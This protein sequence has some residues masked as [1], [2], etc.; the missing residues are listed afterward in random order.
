M[1]FRILLALLFPLCVW[2]A[3]PPIRVMS[4]NIRLALDSDG[5]NSWKNRKTDVLSLFNYYQP[6][7]FGVQEALPE[8]INE[9]KNGVPKYQYVG[10]GRDDGRQ[11]G[12]FSAIFYD[13]RKYKTLKSGTF[14]LSETPEKPSKG[15][16]AAY[17][18]VCTYSLFKSKANGKKFW[19]FNLHF[20]HVGTI[21]REK[22]AELV[23]AKIK[24]F[25]KANLPVV[26]MGDFN[27]T[28]KT[29]PVLMIK[30]QF[31]DSFEHSK[32]IHYGPAGTFTG[33]DVSKIPTDRID[34]I[35]THKFKV[36]SHRHIN[37]RR[38]NLLYPSD[39]FP[40]FAELQ[41]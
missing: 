40:V 19:I 26:L 15:W 29:T 13:H 11:K 28:P 16:D 12:E 25:N 20:D 36:K 2:A 7:V 18:R 14:W 3:K 9:I 10:V 6:D 33:F 35:F 32:N 27:L 17:N 30:K 4:Y 23:L 5:Q 38:P 37:D 22:S 41:F 34:Y 24:D 31:Q 8:Q 1:K 39:H 21:A